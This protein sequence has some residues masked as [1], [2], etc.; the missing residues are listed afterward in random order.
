MFVAFV[1]AFVLVL[2]HWTENHPDSDLDCETVPIV[3]SDMR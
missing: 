1:T 3:Y 2:R